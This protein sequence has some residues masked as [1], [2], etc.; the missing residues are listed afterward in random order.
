[1]PR[2]IEET[3]FEPATGEVTSGGGMAP[4]VFT[5]S[6]EAVPGAWEAGRGL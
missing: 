1:M 5:E 6:A 3:G 4:M 2:L